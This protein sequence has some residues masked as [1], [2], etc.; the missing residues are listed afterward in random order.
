MRVHN[1]AEVKF[2]AL[3]FGDAVADELVQPG[4]ADAAAAFVVVGVVVGNVEEIIAVVK[5]PDPGQFLLIIR[6]LTLKI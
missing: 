1:L 6:H 2:F 4:N 5:D 3:F